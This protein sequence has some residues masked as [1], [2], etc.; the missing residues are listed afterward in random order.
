M[1]LPI[2]V[3]IGE[4]ARKFDEKLAMEAR[5]FARIVQGKKKFCAGTPLPRT[6]PALRSA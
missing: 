1:S 6:I 3:A 2:A 4:I 5:R